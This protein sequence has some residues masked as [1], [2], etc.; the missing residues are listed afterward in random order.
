MRVREVEV[1]GLIVRLSLPAIK[2]PDSLLVL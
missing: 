2:G 1:M